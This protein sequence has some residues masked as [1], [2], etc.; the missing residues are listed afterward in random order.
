MISDPTENKIFFKFFGY[1][2]VPCLK[3]LIDRFSSVLVFRNADQFIRK[4]QD[5]FINKFCA[6]DYLCRVI[7]RRQ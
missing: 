7:Y 5:K 1:Y 4:R 2:S 6:S 3:T